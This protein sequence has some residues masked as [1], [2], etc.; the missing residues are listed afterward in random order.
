MTGRLRWAL[1]SQ[2]AG[3]LVTIG[4]GMATVILLARVLDHEDYGRFLT[5]WSLVVVCSALVRVGTSRAVLR[6]VPSRLGAGDVPGADQV[7]GA[8]WRLVGSAALALFPLVMTIAAYVVPGASWSSNA[9]LLI[10]LV[11]AFEATRLVGEAILLAFGWSAGSQLL[12]SP[13]RGVLFLLVSLVVARW[14][15]PWSLERALAALLVVNASVT[16]LQVALLARVRPGSLRSSGESVAWQRLL[17][18]APAFLA[19]DAAA[20]VLVQGDIV[21]AGRALDPAVVGSYAVASRLGSLFALPS[22]VVGTTITPRLARLVGAGET[23]QALRLTRR[24][25]RLSCSATLVA[26]AG[27]ALLGGPLVR[28]LFG[29]GFDDVT[30]LTL[31]VA[32]GAALASYVTFAGVLLIVARRERSVVAV[33]AGSALGI[34]VLGYPAG[35]LLGPAGLAGVAATVTAAQA[36]LLA[37]LLRLRLRDGGLVAASRTD[38]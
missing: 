9:V 6:D 28:M 18:S 10:A 8:G 38:S 14:A 32:A 24:A 3:Q 35:R 29:P 7:A 5:A 27:F 25:S 11:T 37:V 4:T 16:V 15:V 31:I 22:A 26:V 13:L 33:L 12:G 21:V 23:A 17:R 19:L 2:S 30:R 1:G 34:L 20:V 36:W